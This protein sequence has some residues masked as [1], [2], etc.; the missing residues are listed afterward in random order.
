M[1]LGNSSSEII[2]AS[3]LKVP[4]LN[5]GDRQKLRLKSN[6]VIDASTTFSSIKNSFKLALKIKK[7]KINAIFY[8]RKTAEKIARS[9]IYHLLKD[10]IEKIKIFYEKK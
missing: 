2:E 10:K 3:T 6:N 7:Q 8:K 5:I 1:I 9:T 4:F